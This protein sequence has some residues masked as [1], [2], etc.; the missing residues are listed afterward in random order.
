MVEKRHIDMMEPDAVRLA[1]P[2]L[3]EDD[4]ILNSEFVQQLATFSLAISAKRIADALEKANEPLNVCAT[5]EEIQ[6]EEI[7]FASMAERIG[8]AVAD[9]I[10]MALRTPLNQYGEDI[11]SA[12][13]GQ[14]IRGQRR[15]E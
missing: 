15:I 7:R 5:V 9:S 10:V 4:G 11:G 6:G 3:S 14:I 13:Q 8:K 1:E 12:I 2:Y